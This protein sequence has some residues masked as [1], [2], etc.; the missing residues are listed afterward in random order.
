MLSPPENK[1]IKGEENERE[2]LKAKG[3]KE[4]G[5]IEVCLLEEGKGK[6]EEQ[7]MDV[8][9]EDIK[10][11]TGMRDFYIEANK[12]KKE[13]KK[14]EHVSNLLKDFPNLKV[15]GLLPDPVPEGG[16][17]PIK[18]TSEWTMV[19]FPRGRGPWKK[20]VRPEP[21]FNK[22]PPERNWAHHP[23]CGT[24]CVVR[25]VPLRRPHS[26]ERFGLAPQY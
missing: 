2:M 14:S 25:S 8:W 10:V 26:Q 9:E 23:C 22:P 5:K 12:R 21:T 16:G 19:D 20:V 11:G 17:V 13:E 24:I 15:G 4:R 7:M 18:E 3:D 6:E 1:D